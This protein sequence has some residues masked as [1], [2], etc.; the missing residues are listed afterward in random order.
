MPIYI[1]FTLATFKRVYIVNIKTIS[2]AN[3]AARLA[4]VFN[5]IIYSF[6]LAL[7]PNHYLTSLWVNIDLYKALQMKIRDHQLMPFE[8]KP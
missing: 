6:E 3:A 8:A 7:E 1:K 4:T 2:S 5:E